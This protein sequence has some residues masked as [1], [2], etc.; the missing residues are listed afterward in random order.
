MMPFWTAF[1]LGFILACFASIGCLLLA[2]VI[3][4]K[5]GKEA[6]ETSELDEAIAEARA[7]WRKSGKPCTHPVWMACE[8]VKLEQC[9]ICD[10]QRKTKEVTE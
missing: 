6:M 1:F 8:A 2:H 7:R 10:E 3:H 5:G 4:N 9:V